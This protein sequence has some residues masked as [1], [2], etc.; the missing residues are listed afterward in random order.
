MEAIGLRTYAFNNCVGIDG[1]E[2]VIILDDG[3]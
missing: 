3:Y 2:W 1:S